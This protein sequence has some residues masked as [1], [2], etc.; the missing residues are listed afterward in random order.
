MAS[1][2]LA[3]MRI[4]GA[5]AEERE[6]GQQEGEIEKKIEHGVARS[7]NR[8]E[9]AEDARRGIGFRGGLVLADIGFS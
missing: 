3:E 8:R 4:A 6:P 2:A 5:A 7:A 1:E 9:Q